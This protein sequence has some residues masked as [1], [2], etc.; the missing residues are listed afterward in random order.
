[1][2][3]FKRPA[4]STAQPLSIATDISAIDGRLDHLRGIALSSAY[5]KQRESL[6]KEFSAFQ[7]SLPGARLFFQLLLKM[8]VDF[9]LGKIP[10]GNTGPCFHLPVS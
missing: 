4:L 8:F 1:M 2:C 6:K 7:C 10:E 9:L 3:G 5:A